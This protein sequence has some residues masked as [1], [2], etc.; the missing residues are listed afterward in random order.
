MDVKTNNNDDEHINIIIFNCTVRQYLV[1][2][3]KMLVDVGNEIVCFEAS[4]ADY[5][6]FQVAVP[7][8]A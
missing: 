8:G 1:I 6:G 7:T 4:C 3:T 2:S 5:V